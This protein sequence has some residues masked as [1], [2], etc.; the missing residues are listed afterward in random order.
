M[1]AAIKCAKPDEKIFDFGV[2][3]EV[4]PMSLGIETANKE[5]DII[6]P[7]GTKIPTTLKQEYATHR[8]NQD[9]AWIRIFQGE[10]KARAVDNKLLGDFT[11]EGIPPN[12]QGKEVVVVS[13]H[14]D[15][16]GILSVE[17]ICQSNKGSKKMTVSE[18][19]KGIMTNEV[20]ERLIQEVLLFSNLLIG[21]IFINY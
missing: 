12:G 6:I 7:K 17:A 1:Q 9:S 14:I 19:N 2:I 15:A 3:Q 8:D 16:N 21:V 20:K 18:E 4:T 11:L 10:K 13:M 5:F